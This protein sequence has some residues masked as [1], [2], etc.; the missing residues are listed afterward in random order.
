M[1]Q[2]LGVGCAASPLT[3][4][5]APMYLYQTAIR[6]E[7]SLK[8]INDMTQ[9]VLVSSHDRHQPGQHQIGYSSTTIIGLLGKLAINNFSNKINS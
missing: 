3:T 4:P 7:N 5:L 9:P 1:E 8:K 2:V 6:K